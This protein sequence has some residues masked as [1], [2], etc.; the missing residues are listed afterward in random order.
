MFRRP[1][2]PAWRLGVVAAVWLLLPTDP[3]RVPAQYIYLDTN[4]DGVHTDED[5]VG[6]VGTTTVDIWLHTNVNKDGTVVTCG[7]GEELGIS[8]YSFVLHAV[9]GTVTWGAYTNNVP[10]PR[11]CFASMFDATDF[12][13]YFCEVP[14]EPAGLYRLGTLTLQV[15]GGSPSL[16][17]APSTPLNGLARTEF[18]TQCDAIGS[19]TATFGTQWFDADGARYGGW[20]NPPLLAQPPTMTAAENARTDETLT[21]TDADGGTFIFS[22][23]SGPPF[24]TVGTS[25]SQPGIGTGYVRAEPSYDDSGWYWSEV[26]VSDGAASD[27]K[28][29]RTH[30]VNVDRAPVLAPVKAI[31]VEQGEVRS[32]RFLASDADHDSIIMSARGVPPFG[33]FVAGISGPYGGYGRIDFNVPPDEPVGSTTMTLVADDGSL[34]DSQ[35]VEVRVA[36]LGGCSGRAPLVGRV[37]PNPMRSFGKLLFW[38]SKVGRL[39]VTLHDVQGRLVRVLLDDPSAAIGYHQV[40]IDAAYQYGPSLPSGV[41]FYRIE[42]EEGASSGRFMIVR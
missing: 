27:F 29:F 14:L 12:Y 17:F 35:E 32:V 34:A 39:R 23:L 1:R 42:G 16:L 31:C 22:R 13:E 15:A 41:Y 36:Y 21:A 4:G 11:G 7:S 30:V 24:L 19:N 5:T 3:P 2:F 8:S 28:S 18:G 37:A 26:M 6:P 38:T 9:G 33:T 10:I 25:S 20:I 40:G